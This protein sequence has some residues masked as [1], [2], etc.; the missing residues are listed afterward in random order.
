MRLFARDA[1][2]LEGRVRAR[3]IDPAIRWRSVPDRAAPWPLMS[4][5]GPGP[6]W[7][8]ATPLRLLYRHDR[9]D[10]ILDI[11]PEDRLVAISASRT[12]R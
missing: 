8:R 2:M 10:R 3:S 12:R 4:P 7:L 1:S 11:R 5:H 9:L 6:V